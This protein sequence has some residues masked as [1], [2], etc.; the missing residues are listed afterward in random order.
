[1]SSSDVLVALGT[2]RLRSGR[3]F[4]LT[5]A[6]GRSCTVVHVD[7]SQFDLTIDSATECP[8]AALGGWRGPIRIAEVDAVA[9]LVGGPR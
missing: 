6:A 4:R 5:D 2:V 3:A 1:V 9:H 7:G 8:V